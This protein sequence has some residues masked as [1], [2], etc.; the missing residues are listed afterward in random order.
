MKINTLKLLS[1]AAFS[2]CFAIVSQAQSVSSTPVG[3][4]TYTVNA[5]S[6]LKLGIPME[7]A[8]SYTGSVSS[9]T[10]GTIDAGSA[11][12]DLTT[13]AHY[14]KVTSG[15]LAGN[16][17]EV[18]AAADNSITVAEDL[19]A[20]GLAAADTFQVTPFWTLDTLFPSGGGVPASADVFSGNAF[21]FT[22]NPADIGINL[23]TASGYL[24][25]SG[26]QGPA[27]WYDSNTISP[28]GSTALSPDVY[29]QVR[30]L[31]S[32][33]ADLVIAGTV[34]SAVTTHTIVSSAST[35]NDNLVYNP[36]PSDITLDTSNLYESGA[37]AGSSDVFSPTDIVFV[38]STNPTGLNISTTSGYMYHTGEQGPAGWYDINTI[39]PAGSTAI[40]DGQPVLIRKASGAD[41]TAS[42]TPALPYSL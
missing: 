10:A 40:A 35:S 31:T 41:A 21:I 6:D 23:S 16:W 30:N 7:Q 8:S 18:T 2:A 32:N 27:G 9:V 42:W 15:T 34:P 19:A 24:Y 26:E 28:A 5:N 1:C 12:G 4:V 14:V 22:Y 38:Y 36:Y 3:Y 11:V 37:V 13:D 25:H 17:Y 39:S 33:S 20:A 29:I